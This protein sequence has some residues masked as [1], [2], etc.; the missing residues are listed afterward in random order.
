MN[1]K[2]IWGI[3]FVVIILLGYWAFTQDWRGN[4]PTG[5]G[6]EELPAATYTNEKYGFE[7]KYPA[8]WHMLMG[9]EKSEIIQL[10]NVDTPSGDGGPPLGARIEVIIFEAYLGMNFEENIREIRGEA[11]G[12]EEISMEEIEVGGHTAYK[13]MFPPSFDDLKEGNPIEVYL[14]TKINFLEDYIILVKYMGRAPDYNDNLGIFDYVLKTWKF[15]QELI[16]KEIWQAVCEE[17][18][19][20]WHIWSYWQEEPACDLPYVDGGQECIDS[21]DCEGTLCKY[22]GENPVE[23][24]SATGECQS[25]HSES[26]VSHHWFVMQ[27]KL[28]EQVCIE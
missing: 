23:G 15:D 7:F 14:S 8:D 5:P 18:G 10:S 13:Y 20:R 4:G 24:E 25:W 1:K 2:I 28:V 19:G 17:A 11:L 6:G 3:V 26:C 9:D 22:M 21:S 12:S 16:N 27:G